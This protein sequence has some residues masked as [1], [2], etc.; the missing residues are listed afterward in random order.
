MLESVREREWASAGRMRRRG[1]RTCRGRGVVVAIDKGD[2]D[3][4]QRNGASW[5]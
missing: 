1:K 4:E 2:G 5:W 3:R